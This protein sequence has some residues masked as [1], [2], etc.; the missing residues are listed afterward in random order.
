[1]EEDKLKSLRVRLDETHV[2]PC[3]FTFKFIVS[4]RE[5]DRLLDTLGRPEASTRPSA[6]GRYVGV[7]FEKR[8]SSSEEV[9]DVF[10]RAATVP[11]VL[12]L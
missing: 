6:G 12:A 3:L 4:N 11:G 2:W 1:M 5:L 7:T 8:V 10:R 9:A